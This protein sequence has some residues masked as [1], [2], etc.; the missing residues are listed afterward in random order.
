MAERME[1]CLAVSS[2]NLFS[3]SPLS[4]PSQ[5]PV[6]L[7]DIVHWLTT[8]AL[9]IFPRLSLHASFW[10]V[11]IAVKFTDLFFCRI[12]SIVY[13]I[14]FFSSSRN[15]I[16]AFFIFLILSSLCQAFLYILQFLC[17]IYKTCFKVLVCEF[18]HL[19][20]FLVC[21]Y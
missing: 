12:E 20:H 21:F 11:S 18:H 6:R 15:S 14:Q 13:A 10:I 1:K 4:F 17:K 9:F 16:L 8:V 5:T 7:L 19:C 2:L 3:H